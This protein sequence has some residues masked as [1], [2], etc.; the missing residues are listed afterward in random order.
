MDKIIF[1]ID[2]NSAFLS[3]SA[4]S[5]LK[6]DPH[7]VDLRSIPSI[8]GG[9]QKSRHG[10]VLAKS[11]PAKKYHIQTGEPIV[12]ALR[13]CP[14]LVIQPPDI[15]LYRASS[16]LLIDFLKELTPDIEQVSI[17][18]CYLDYTGI[19]SLYPSYLETAS[20]IKDTIKETFG[21]TVN[22]GISTNKLLAKMASDFEK[23]DNIHTLFPEEVPEKMWPLPIDRLYMAGRSSVKTLEN[24]DIM[25]IGDLAHADP[26]IIVSHLKSHGKMLWDYANGIGPDELTTSHTP[27]K[28]I[29]NSITLREDVTT[30]EEAQAILKKLSIQVSQRLEKAGQL[31]GSAC[32]EI[33]YNTF[34]S[35]SHQITVPEPFSSWEVLY[36][37]ACQLFEETW[38]QSP[39]R[40]LG[41]RTTKLVDQESPIQLSLFDLKPEPEQALQTKHKMVNQALESIKKKYGEKSVQRGNEL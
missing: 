26:D 16:H 17:D 1:H 37:Y 11:V 28:G 27:A 6:E 39:V 31:A 15:K 7:S 33:K 3:W 14:H 41:I 34:Q 36:Q 32:V 5:L 38:T 22:I 29:G 24:L 2:V 23:P 4:V 35:V 40:L 21:F 30:L 10:I 12:H 13:K 20:Y 9:D 25:T 19:S 8:I 18:E